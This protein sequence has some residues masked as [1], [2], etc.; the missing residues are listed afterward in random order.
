MGKRTITRRRGT[1][2]TRYRA[3]SHRFKAEVKYPG[4]CRKETITGQVVGFYKDVARYT[5]LAKIMLE[6]NYDV[7]S[8]IAPEGMKVGDVVEMGIGA[9]VNVG[10]VLPIGKMPEGTSIYNVELSPGDGGKFVRSSGV[11][12]SVVSHDKDTGRTSVRLPSKRSIMLS[13]NC[14]ATVGKA[15]GGGRK[16]KPFI[17]AGQKFHLY[18][19]K[20]RL[21]PIVC[22]LH[23]NAV[24]HPHGGGRHPHIGRP[25][26]VSRNTPPGRKV[27]HIA[28]KRT[29]RKKR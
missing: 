25:S 12:A 15:A 20:N 13:S 8:V 17:H 10:N 26:C 21:Y 6:D 2:S 28:P 18:K 4:W 29:G 1:G 5:P 23:M 22:G 24:D 14:L 16:D 3:P 9:P 7:I 19:S 27:G 11:S